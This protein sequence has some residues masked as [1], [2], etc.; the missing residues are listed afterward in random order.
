MIVHI[1]AQW[2]F[3]LSGILKMQEG[4]RGGDT[5]PKRGRKHK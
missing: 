1:H 5:N 3:E 2:D 4:G